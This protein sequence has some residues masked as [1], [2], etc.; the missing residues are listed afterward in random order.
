MTADIRV[1]SGDIHGGRGCKK[2]KRRDRHLIV[3]RSMHVLSYLSSGPIRG[4]VLRGFYRG[5]M[6][7]ESISVD[8]SLKVI[9]FKGFD[10]WCNLQR[11]YTLPSGNV[12]NL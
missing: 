11:P 4:L 1:H 10:V 8:M 3:R 12:R 9:L 2:V 7:R 5:F 6:L